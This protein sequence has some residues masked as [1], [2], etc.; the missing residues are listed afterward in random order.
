MTTVTET[1]RT[2]GNWRRPRRPGL[3]QLGLVG[4]VGVFAGIIIVLV[5]TMMSIYVAGVALFLLAIALAPMVVRT[6]DGRNLYQMVAVR[7]GWRR[8]VA[9]KEHLYVS[10]PLSKRPGGRYRPP[11]VLSRVKVAEGRDAYG[12]PFGVI[13]HRG[14]NLYVIVLVCEPD[15]GS[16]VDPDQVDTWVAMW[17]DW[18]AQLAHEPNLKGASVVVET[19]PDPGTRLANEILPR[20]RDDAPPAARAVM[21][22]VVASYPSTSSEMHTYV[23]LTYGVPTGKKKTQ[24]EVITDL[25]IRIP[26]LM[27]GLIGAGG[28]SAEPV[29]AEGIAD[30]VRVAFDPAVAADVLEARV[31]HGRTGIKWAD[32]G[33]MAAI[34][35]VDA[36]KHDSGVSRSWMLT[37]APRGTVRSGVL[38]GILEDLPG[39]RRKRVAILYRPVDAATAAKIV[40]SDRKA[41]QFMATASGGMVRARASAEIEAAEQTASEEATGAGLV[42]FSLMLTVTVDS[43]SELPDISAAIRN[44]LGA[45]R[46]SVRQADRMQAMAFACT[47]PVGI[48]PWKLTLL[49]QE[50]QE[51]M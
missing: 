49:P 45:S 38:R 6:A 32:A 26:G 21:Q 36:Y 18:L 28:G 30:I 34:E 51:A 46:L 22:E 14:E 24:E 10:G 1:A 2:Y 19:A 5:A 29:S 35:T 11:G 25:A 9:K 44:R 23:T 43:P 47:L 37:V 41:A 13:H 17:G 48:L 20:L 7:I 12:R 4:T 27:N 40:E 16:L 31:E 8:R 33:P 3:G 15:G 39:T 50:L 42:E